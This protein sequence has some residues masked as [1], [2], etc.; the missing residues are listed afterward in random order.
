MKLYND[1]CIKVMQSFED[2]SIDCIFIY[3]KTDYHN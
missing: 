3:Q 1:D 2:N